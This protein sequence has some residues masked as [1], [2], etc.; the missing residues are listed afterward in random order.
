VNFIP[1]KIPDIILVKP[2]IYNDQRGYFTETFR[3]DLLED[4]I[5]YQVNFVQDNLSKSRLGVLRG[6]H[7]QLPPYCQAKLIKIIE[8]RV[9]D[10]AVDIRKNSS[11]FGHHMAIELISE[12]QDQLFIPHGF[13]H[14]FLA[15]TNS[16]KLE[17]KVDNYYSKD[18]EKGI[19]FNDKQLNINW[20]IPIEK[21][22]ISD[23]DLQYPSLNAITQ[24]L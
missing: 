1:Q 7:F 24:L 11:T 15:L 20:K 8:G 18:H 4:F 17:Y 12:N 16:V 13:A 10:I 14:G 23:K 19:S 22:I 5:G 9:L 3:Q 21:L 2:T 6:L